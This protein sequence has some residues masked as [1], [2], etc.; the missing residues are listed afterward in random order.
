MCGRMGQST[1]RRERKK[2]TLSSLSP[3]THSARGA[4]EVSVCGLTGGTREGRG[5]EIRERRPGARSGRDRAKR[6]S[7]VTRAQRPTT[8]PHITHHPQP[9]TPKKTTPKKTP[10][11]KT[12]AKKTPAKTPARRTPAAAAAPASAV[13]RSARTPARKA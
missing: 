9:V 2:L 11:K 6:L 10:T 1:K 12:P 13:R 7:T 3:R 4:G 5:G 8:T